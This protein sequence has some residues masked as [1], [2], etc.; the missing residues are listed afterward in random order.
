MHTGQEGV[1][2]DALE[3]VVGHARLTPQEMVVGPGL[4]CPFRLQLCPDM[5]QGGDQEAARAAGRV[6]HLVQGPGINHAHNQ[7]HDI[8]RREELSLGPAQCGTDEDL[9]CV[10]DGVPVGL[11]EAVGLQLPDHVQYAGGVQANAVL[12]PEDI[13]VHL[14]LDPGKE[15]VDASRPLRRSRP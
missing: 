5:A 8:A 14:L 15:C 6:Q 13:P 2:V 3:L 7:F 1:L 11:H 4:A 9:E 12:R 10:A